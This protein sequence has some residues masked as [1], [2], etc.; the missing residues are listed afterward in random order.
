MLTDPEERARYEESQAGVSETEALL[1][2]QAEQLFQRGEMLI[3]AGNFRG[4]AQFL[5][6]AVQIYGSEPAYH[7]AYAW[8]LH[9]Q[10]PP[11][12]AR[13]LT[14]FEQALAADGEDAQALLRMSIVVKELGDEA[15][16]TQLASRARAIDAGVRA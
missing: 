9:R 3:R 2:A 11:D 13:A 7:A 15:R 10:N 16:A 6:R 1:A 5:E 12:N 8:A 14:H 4:A